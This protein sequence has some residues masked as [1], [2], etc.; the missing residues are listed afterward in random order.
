MKEE[1]EVRKPTLMLDFQSDEDLDQYVIDHA[2]MYTIITPRP[3]GFMAGLG[4]NYS[5]EEVHVKDHEGTEEAL[6]AAIARAKEM[7]D[8]SENKKTLLIYAV[9]DFSGAIGF[10]R[11]VRQYPPSTYRSKADKKRDELRDRKL[12]REAKKAKLK[13]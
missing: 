6:V 8:A 5:R 11:P 7:Y 4:S 12:A 13:A 3:G 10:S 9:A 1:I 2:Y